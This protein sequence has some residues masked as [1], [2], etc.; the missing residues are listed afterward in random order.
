[1][2]G[3]GELRHEPTAKR[4]RAQ[5]GEATVVDSTRAALVWEPRRVVPTYAVPV[6]D[7]RAEL[8]PAGAAPADT[9]EVGFSIPGLSS[10]PVLDPSI[11]F[12]VH[13]ADGEVVDVQVTGQTLA[14]A[15]FRRATRR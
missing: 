6:E 11:P 1:M 10:R 13:T 8:T 14:A 15:G 7:V 5:L 12:G 2:S 3:L 4:I 9:E